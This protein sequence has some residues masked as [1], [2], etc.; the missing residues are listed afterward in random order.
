MKHAIS[1]PIAGEILRRF[2]SLLKV[3]RVR[4]VMYKDIS[5]AGFAAFARRSGAKKTAASLA[6]V[7]LQ[8][9][10]P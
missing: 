5:R 8:D 6:A 7:F 2:G 4:L 9:F 1:H 3:I 10:R